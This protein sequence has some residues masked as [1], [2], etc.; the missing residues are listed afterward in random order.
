MESA[1]SSFTAVLVVGAPLVVVLSV[2]ESVP[3]SFS[4][5]VV[6]CCCIT[7]ESVSSSF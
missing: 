1:V 3:S 2:V 4:A 7:V 5:T 6:A